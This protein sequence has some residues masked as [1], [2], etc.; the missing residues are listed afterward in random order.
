MNLVYTLDSYSTLH[1]KSEDV[2]ISKWTPSIRSWKPK[3]KPG[4][5]RL[6][7]LFH[8]FGVFSN[9]DYSAI[10]LRQNG[11]LKAS[12]LVVPR[13]YRW[14]FMGANDLQF[15]YVVTQTTERGKGWGTILLSQGVRI[16]RKKNRGIWYVTDTHNIASQRLA[17]KVGFKRVG[18]A[19][20]NKRFFISKLE[21]RN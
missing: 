4:K 20:K 17:E 1:E 7:A 14:P 18:E 9:S 21:L 19:E 15:T 11:A 6:F 5:Y 10:C 2:V 8:W 13:Y 16:F 12:M 3:D